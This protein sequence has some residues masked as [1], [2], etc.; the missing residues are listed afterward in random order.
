MGHDSGQPDGLAG[1]NT[2]RALRDFQ[3]ANQLDAD[4]YV[5][6]SAYDAVMAAGGRK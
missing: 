4:G 5:G 1:P 3:R 6:I 2:R